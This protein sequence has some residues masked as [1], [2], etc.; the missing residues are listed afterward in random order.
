MKKCALLL[1]MVVV[2]G[3]VL[4]G[5]GTGGCREVCRDHLGGQVGDDQSDRYGV[6]RE[7][8]NSGS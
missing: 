6:P 4:A 1:A 5:A 2:L 8:K 7:G 3:A